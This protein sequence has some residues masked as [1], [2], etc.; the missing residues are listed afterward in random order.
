[1]ELS[2]EALQFELDDDDREALQTMLRQ[3]GYKVLLK[4]IDGYVGAMKDGAQVV[5]LQ[6]PLAN[7]EKIGRAWAYALI[8]QNLRLSL[9]NGVALELEMLKK[10]K[11]EKINAD[12]LA[13]MRRRRFT[14]EA[15]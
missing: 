10:H 14:L 7:G 2:Q 3:P 8:A 12:E 11:N 6:E 13:E 5:S 1:M 15:V 9:E 4:I